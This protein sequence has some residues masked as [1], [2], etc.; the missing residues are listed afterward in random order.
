MQG[1]PDSSVGIETGYGL[2]D[3]GIEFE[4]RKSKQFYLLLVIQ[5]RLCGLMV[6]VPDYR[7]R[8][9]DS[10]PGTTRFSEK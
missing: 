1:S 10:I 6:R 2:N 7:S 5:E 3:R 9:P 4:S 8:G